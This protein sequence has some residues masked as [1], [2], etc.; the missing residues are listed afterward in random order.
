[1]WLRVT[2]PRA[3]CQALL[4]PASMEDICVQMKMRKAVMFKAQPHRSYDL[5]L[6]LVHKAACSNAT[7]TND[8]AAGRRK[9]DSQGLDSC[10]MAS[11]T[12]LDSF[13]NTAHR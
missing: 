7:R 8:V 13:S 9:Q 11:A 3:D 5:C 10:C 1:M 4:T 12:D 6:F 2:S